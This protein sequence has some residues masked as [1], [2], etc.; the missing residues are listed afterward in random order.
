MSYPMLSAGVLNSIFFGAYG[1]GISVIKK[2]KSVESSKYQV[3]RRS[4]NSLP[5]GVYADVH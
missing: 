1:F 3:G 2:A 5:A 4:Y